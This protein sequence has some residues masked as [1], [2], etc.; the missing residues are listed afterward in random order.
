M[1]TFYDISYFEVLLWKNSLPVFDTEDGR[2][3]SDNMKTTLPKWKTVNTRNMLNK[4]YPFDLSRKRST[5]FKV[6]F[7]LAF[8]VF[9]CLH[10]TKFPYE[11]IQHGN[12]LNEENYRY[13]I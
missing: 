5:S 10:L 11:N 7:T 6:P 9:V 1:L 8:A 3:K 4:F 13:I 2:R 12:E